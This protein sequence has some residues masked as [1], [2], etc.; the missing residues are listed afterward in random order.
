MSTI[1]TRR[2]QNTCLACGYTWFPRGKDVSAVC[3]Q[4]QDPA[5]AIVIPQGYSTKLR[6][7]SCRQ[8]VD[9]PG[10]PA[11]IPGHQ[12]CNRCGQEEIELL[13]KQHWSAC[14]TIIVGLAIVVA[15]MVLGFIL[16]SLTQ[17]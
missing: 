9:L 3:P 16:L 4:C 7:V 2:L 10:G 5:T 13:L 15:L 8:T 6:C 17:A 1:P 11:T 12:K 14:T